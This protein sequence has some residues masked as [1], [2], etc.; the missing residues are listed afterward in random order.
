ML[1]TKMLNA[2]ISQNLMAAI[3]LIK[4]GEL[5]AVP[6]ETV[7]GLAA[8]AKNIN[9]VKKIFIAKNRPSNHPLIVHIASVEK[10]S[11]WAKEIPAITKVLAEHFWPGPLTI[12]LKKI[13]SV[14]DIVTGGLETIAIR[15]PN[16]RALLKIINTLDTGLAAPSAN[17][18][19][20]I[21][22]TTPEHVMFGLSGKIAAILDSGPC[23]IGIESTILDLTKSTPQI[24]RHGPITKK[25]LENVLKISIDAPQEHSE[26]IPGNMKNHYQ[27]YTES[28]LISFDQIEKII[29][30]E[31]N[32]RKLFGIM[33]HSDFKDKHTNTLR[34][35][36][37][38]DKSD[39]TRLM[40]DTLHYLDNI[41][42]NKILIEHPPNEED[43]Q[44]VLDRL[45]K[46]TSRKNDIG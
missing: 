27:P 35:K 40:Y 4:Q 21:S 30:S 3:S 41:H 24:L 36:M 28:L 5:V 46:A 26:I 38:T 42:A 33:H 19:K 37:P 6:T 17:L 34:K 44:D 31:K 45:L 22:P 29:S 2:N 20:K 18:Y 16:N 1:K 8:D 10:L 43:W 9:A 14:N 11:E 13:E 23:E 12:V 32:S 15:V 7:Y 25:M 39:Y